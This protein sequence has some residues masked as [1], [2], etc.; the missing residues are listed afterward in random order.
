MA[1]NDL[2]NR[3]K[4]SAAKL[5]E[6]AKKVLEVMQEKANEAG[7]KISQIKYDIDE[8]IINPV[9]ITD[10]CEEGFEMPNLVRIFEDDKKMKNEVCKN[11]VGFIDKIKEIKILNL[12][13]KDLPKINEHKLIGGKLIFE[14][15]ITE[16]LYYNDPYQ[17]NRFI[18]LDNYFDFI[19]TG[20]LNELERI[21][22]DLQAKHILIDS[23]EEKKSFISVKGKKHIGA[24]DKVEEIPVKASQE[25]SA[26]VE[27]SLAKTIEI[28][29]E[30]DMSGGNNPKE[31][32]LLFFK[33]NSDIKNLIEMR[34]SPDTKIYHKTYMLKYSSIIG[35]NTNIASKIDA[36]IAFYKLNSNTSISGEIE[37]ENRLYLKYDIDFQ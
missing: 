23:Y 6:D 27:F 15:Y 22:F 21:A 10:M 5:E 12:R 28:H 25:S 3:I 8:R 16:S 19:K 24:Q 37:D 31:P 20:T 11:A 34:M 2:K 18:D 14:P 13:L 30:L 35:I 29:K 32:N 4:S 7:K 33:G 17:T 26:N 9:T 1:N 36:A